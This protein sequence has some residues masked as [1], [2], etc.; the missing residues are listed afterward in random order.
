MLCVFF[1][2]FPASPDLKLGC[3]L[4]TTNTSIYSGIQQMNNPTD[5]GADLRR[6]GASREFHQLCGEGVMRVA[7]SLVQIINSLG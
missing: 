3:I 4:K 1:V 7:S 5:L 6:V 2:A